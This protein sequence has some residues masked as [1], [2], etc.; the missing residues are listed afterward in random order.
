M[1]TL[2]A[3]GPRVLYVHAQDGRT[4]ATA[5][6][7]NLTQSPRF[8]ESFASPTD[9]IGYLKAI[10]KL[11]PG[12]VRKAASELQ[13]LHSATARNA[14]GIILEAQ[15]DDVGALKAFQQA[16]ELE[17]NFAEAAYNA[18]TLLARKGRYSAAILQIQSVLRGGQTGDDA[19]CA[20]RELLAETKSN[21]GQDES[22]AEILNAFS[23]ECP[24]SP[25]VHFSLGLADVRLGRLPDAVIQFQ[26]ELRLKPNEANGLLNLAKAL[27]DLRNYSESVPYLEQYIP[28]RPNDAQGYYA[29]GYALQAMDRSKEAVEKLSLAAR[30]SPKDYNVRFYLGMVLWESG[31]PEAALPEF[32]AAERLK[33]EETQVHFE[34]ARLLVKLNMKRRAVEESAWAQ[35][36]SARGMQN[37]QVRADACIVE[38]NLLRERGELDA[39]AEQFRQ[40]STLDSK[41]AAARYQ[42]G[43]VLAELNEP[44]SARQEFKEAITLNAKFAFA[45]NALGMS[46]KK[47]G[48]YS[49]AA[50][51]FEGA[52]RINP[53]FAE[54]KNNLGTLYATQG[55]NNKALILFR[56]ATEDSP[57]YAVAYLNWGLLLGNEGDLRGAKK[58]FEK[59]LQLSP[60]LTEAQRDL[61]IANEALNVQVN[62][63]R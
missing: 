59:A 27:L 14:L 43:L 29:L 13:L 22:A 1:L 45:Y 34:L 30:L 20:L 15:C 53:Q 44:Q 33:P 11:K 25:Q 38:G 9:K 26:E 18:A 54:A 48:K 12:E 39:A 47:E 35:R 52:I 63:R 62:A 10:K 23:V 50:E 19:A 46:Y 42:L 8:T 32:E 17:P 41:N 40:A 51:A 55:E 31:R 58:M 2:L 4:C 49:E 56:E 57:G 24:D 3:I 28:L 60:E 16:L 7:M 5:D 61:H 21:I 6:R 37:Y 36:A